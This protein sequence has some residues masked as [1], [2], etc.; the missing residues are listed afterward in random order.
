MLFM[1][2]IA[3][4]FISTIASEIW[5][6]RYMDQ[7]WYLAFDGNTLIKAYCMYLVEL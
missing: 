2:L 5:T 7:L 1:I 4:S 3:L 6:K